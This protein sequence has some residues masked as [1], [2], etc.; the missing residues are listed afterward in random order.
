DQPIPE[1]VAQDLY[2][3]HRDQLFREDTMARAGVGGVARF[4]TGIAASLLDP[5]SVASAFIPGVGEARAAQI[6]GAGAGGLESLSTIGRIGARAIAGASSGLIGTT[7][8][9]PIQGALSLAERA[10]YTMQD[11]LLNMAMGTVMGG[12]L[13][14]VGGAVGDLVTGRYRNPIANALE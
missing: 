1:S 13:H 12:G 3:H 5:V 11:A 8:L 2:E 4:T 10:D 7:A 6:L 14:V 9:Q